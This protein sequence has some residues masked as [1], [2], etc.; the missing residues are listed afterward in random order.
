MPCSPVLVTGTP[1]G[2][3]LY[4]RQ[5]GLDRHCS[6]PCPDPVCC[7]PASSRFLVALLAAPEVPLFWETPFYIPLECSAADPASIG[8]AYLG[9]LG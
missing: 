3:L 7:C 9:D 5:G 6:C 4:V 8:A 2:L 1:Q